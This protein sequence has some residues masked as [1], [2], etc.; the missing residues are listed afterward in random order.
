LFCQLDRPAK[1]DSSRSAVDQARAGVVAKSAH[2][3]IRLGEV[4][5][6]S[7]VLET[8]VGD[9]EVG[10]REGT[11]AWL[12]VNTSVGNVHNALDAAEA[13][14]PSAPTVEVRARTSFGDVLIRRPPETD[15]QQT[16][17]RTQ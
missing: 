9:V 16:H 17:R 1:R 5:S 2:G 3:N 11:A 10:I 8:R 6:G 15:W 14:E 4:V 12:D 7:V 13:P